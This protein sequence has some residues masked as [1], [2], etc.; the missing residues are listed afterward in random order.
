M[1]E[2][3]ECGGGGGGNEGGKITT[4]RANILAGDRGNNQ[5]QLLKIRGARSPRRLQ[6]ALHCTSQPLGAHRCVAVQLSAQGARDSIR[7]GKRCRSRLSA[8]QQRPR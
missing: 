2:K 7:T 1:G 8:E 6:F 5:C 4:K 3:V